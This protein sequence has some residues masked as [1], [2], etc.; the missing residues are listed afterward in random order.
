MKPSAPPDRAPATGI[1]N[2]PAMPLPIPLPMVSAPLAM[3]VTTFDGLL[4]WSSRRRSLKLSSS[5][6]S[7]R[8][9]PTDPVIRDTPSKMPKTELRSND[10]VPATGKLIRRLPAQC[11]HR[12]EERQGG[13]AVPR[14]NPAA[15]LLGDSMIP[16][17][18]S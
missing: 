17:Y 2:T 16:W 9:L 11:T 5:V 1:V 15:K 6:A 10:A 18:G 3:P 8:P 4:R 12:T 13:H 14:P 7:A